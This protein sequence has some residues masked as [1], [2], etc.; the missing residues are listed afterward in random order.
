MTAKEGEEERGGGGGGVAVIS[1]DGMTCSHFLMSSEKWLHDWSSFESNK[2]A[3][4]QIFL[5]F[6]VVLFTPPCTQLDPERS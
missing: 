2:L 4:I 5:P 6:F 1:R 3:L